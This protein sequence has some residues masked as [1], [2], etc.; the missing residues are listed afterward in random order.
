[1]RCYDRLAKEVLVKVLG[2]LLARLGFRLVWA[3]VEFIATWSLD[4]VNTK[5][6]TRIARA[7]T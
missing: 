5:P 2:H 7:R 1:V 6:L 3:A 4:T